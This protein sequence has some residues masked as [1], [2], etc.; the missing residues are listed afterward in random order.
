VAHRLDTAGKEWPVGR[1]RRDTAHTL[2]GTAANLGATHMA[3][4]CQ[5]IEDLDGSGDGTELDRLITELERHTPEVT[6]ALTR[7]ADARLT[8][9]ARPGCG[10]G[11][12]HCQRGSRGDERDEPDAR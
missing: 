10:A 11:R 1:R 3:A 7:A 12:L 4:L 5:R 6:A 9:V 8:V 2:K